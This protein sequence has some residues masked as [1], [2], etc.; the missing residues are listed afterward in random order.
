MLINTNRDTQIAAYVVESAN[1][2]TQSVADSG[3]DTVVE[4]THENPLVALNSVDVVVSISEIARRL[5]EESI[6][7]AFAL[8]SLAL[9]LERPLTKKN[10]KKN[11]LF[12]KPIMLEV[13]GFRLLREKLR[14]KNLGI[15]PPN[16]A[17]EKLQ[18]KRRAETQIFDL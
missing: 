14:A 11:S 8:E 13:D 3:R 6:K 2:K 18:A 9:L 7:L 10:K 12:A 4:A 15:K 16:L 5:S 1:H 17:L